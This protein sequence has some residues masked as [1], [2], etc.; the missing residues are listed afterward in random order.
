MKRDCDTLASMVVE[1]VDVT[2]RVATN[3]VPD[4]KRGEIFRILEFLVQN[5]KLQKFKNPHAPRGYFY[6]HV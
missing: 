4:V 6:I 5:G 1:V 3:V 2:A